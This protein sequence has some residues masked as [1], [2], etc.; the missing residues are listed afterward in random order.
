MRNF[1]FFRAN[2]ARSV[3]QNIQIHKT[4][5]ARNQLAAPKRMLDPLQRIK[6]LPRRERSF[7]LHDTIQKPRL[8]EKIH[9]LSFVKR[10]PPKYSHAGFWQSVNS[11]LKI[12][13]AV[14]KIRS[15]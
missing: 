5:T 6:Q 2:Y 15:E 11:S 4:G 3:K 13:G 9:R 7:R 8:R 12:R 1:D 10:R 14:A